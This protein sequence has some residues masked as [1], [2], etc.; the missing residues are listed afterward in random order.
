MKKSPFEDNDT[1]ESNA[2]IVDM[3]DKNITRL[4]REIKKLDRGVKLHIATG[5][6]IGIAAEEKSSK[7][8]MEVVLGDNSKATITVE[9]ELH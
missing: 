4:R 2:K 8:T 7:Y 5:V 6:L 9:L 3:S 1:R